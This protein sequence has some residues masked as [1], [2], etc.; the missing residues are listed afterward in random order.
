MTDIVDECNKTINLFHTQRHLEQ[1]ENHWRKLQQRALLGF[2]QQNKLCTFAR[3]NIHA[4]VSRHQHS[5]LPP[6]QK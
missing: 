1:G 2:R 4:D 3:H 5:G 6:P